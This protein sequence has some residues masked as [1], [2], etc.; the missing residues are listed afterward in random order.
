MNK[1]SL[2][3]LILI[4]DIYYFLQYEMKRVRMDDNIE[5]KYEILSKC[6]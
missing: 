2:P 5:R 1:N 6:L 3:Y 4:K